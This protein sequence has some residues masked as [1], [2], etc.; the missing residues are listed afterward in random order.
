MQ[1]TVLKYFSNYY[2]VQVQ[3]AEAS[4]PLLLE[5]MAK[6]LL[7]KQG[8]LVLTGDVVLLDE[9]NLGNKTARITEILPRTAL[10]KKPKIAN[11]QR[12]LVFVPLAQPSLDLRQLDRLLAHVQLSG[13]MPSVIFT[14]ADL[15]L[16]HPVDWQS[17][18]FSS[19]EA[20]LSFYTNRLNIPAIATSIIAGSAYWS[21]ISTLSK[22]LQTVGGNWVLAGVS[23]AGKSSLLNHL[24]PQFH[25]KVGAV[26]D[27][28]ERGTH[29]TRHTELLELFPS[30]WVADAPGFSHLAFEG[31]DP[32]Q[33][34]QG[35]PEFK[36]VTEK[37]PCQF[38]SCLHHTEPDCGIIT[39]VA[40]GLVSNSR[41]LHYT[42]L[43]QEVTETFELVSKQSHKQE[44]GGVKQGNRKQ[45]GK[46]SA[47][48]RLDP[49]LREANR[50]Q[51]NQQLNQL[52]Q[53]LE[54]A[55]QEDRIDE[56]TD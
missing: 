11:V 42:E 2:Y 21:A 33:V 29:T 12:V 28:L 37:T 50:K 7:K 34:Q 49:K 15:L 48:V 46:T 40:Q 41:H 16:T 4:V 56:E 55:S 6:S 52:H 20:L 53:T 18:G 3:L 39:A 47:V 43:L 36:Q 17:L 26:S 27:K 45:G 13:L 10:L 35:F 19:L 30:V 9:V 25:L 22:Q 32:E 5:C 31:I 54:T 14:K 23:G 51:Y 38:P 44:I 8:S 1:G 24:N